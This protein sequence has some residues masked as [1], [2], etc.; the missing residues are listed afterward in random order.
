LWRI[1][2]DGVEPSWLFG[3][4]H[5]DDPAVVSLPRAVQRAFAESE[6]VILEV[7]LDAG[8]LAAM[9]SSLLLSDGATLE[10]IVGPEL[11]RRTLEVMAD[12]GY[13]EMVVAGMKPWA[14]AV[15]L[16]TPPTETG[17]VLDHV[18]YQQAVASGKSVDGLESAAEQ[19]ALFDNLSRAD[20]VAL[21]RD[22]L[23]NL[24]DI[25]EL[26]VQLK[27]AYLDRDLRRLQAINARSMRDSDPRLVATFRDKVI[28]GRNHRMAERMESRL[29]EGNRFIAVGALHLPGEEGLLN[30]LVA[31][32]YRVTRVY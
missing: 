32:G 4:M 12:Q 19:L 14:V 23:D 18:L 8:S 2:A 6:A 29:R 7:R 22:T 13:P 25:R 20:Q 17:L 5:S 21:L 11:Y 10:A 1:D 3:T 9:T 27:D 15:T 31:R 26:L 24:P 16:M 30:L 28:I